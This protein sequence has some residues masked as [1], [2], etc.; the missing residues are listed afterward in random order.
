MELPGP[1]WRSIKP[2]RSMV[3]F[4]LFCILPVLSWSLT[5]A[6]PRP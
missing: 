6:A 1:A 3:E 5:L 2:E 4:L